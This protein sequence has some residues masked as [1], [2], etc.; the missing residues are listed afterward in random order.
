MKKKGVSREWRSEAMASAVELRQRAVE[1]LVRAEFWPGPTT[2]SGESLT[3]D[4]MLSEIALNVVYMD[5]AALVA[6]LW[7]SNALVMPM[8]L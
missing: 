5:R 2:G 8:R 3:R 1:G 7:V 4:L 6:L